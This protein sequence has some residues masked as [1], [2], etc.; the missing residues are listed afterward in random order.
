MTIDAKIFACKVIT[1]IR[2]LVCLISSGTLS[3]CKS[4]AFVIIG[5]SHNRSHM[6]NKS[7]FRELDKALGSLISFSDIIPKNY[8][9]SL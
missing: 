5:R 7:L 4:E 6:K 2:G 8:V 1:G 3:M 9:F